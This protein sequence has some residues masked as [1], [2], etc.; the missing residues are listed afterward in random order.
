[1]AI[2]EESISQIGRSYGCWFQ[3][4]EHRDEG[5]EA[6]SNCE[7]TYVADAEITDATVDFNRY[8]F[9]EMEL[10][11]NRFH[12]GPMGKRADRIINGVASEGQSVERNGE[13][14][15]EEL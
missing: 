3:R 9:Q 15:E 13:A 7:I 11:G 14:D 8:R 6:R 1:M 4:A 10:R 12:R 5:V 2:S